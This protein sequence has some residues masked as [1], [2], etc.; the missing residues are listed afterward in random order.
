M[1]CSDGTAPATPTAEYATQPAGSTR[2][3]RSLAPTNT[4]SLEALA[5]AVP[6]AGTSTSVLTLTLTPPTF[7][8]CSFT[9]SVPDCDSF[10]YVNPYA[11]AN[12]G[13][14]GNPGSNTHAASY[15]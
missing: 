13:S 2:V 12:N 15:L 5:T 8:S 6:I 11:S 4:A 10:S 9:N 1:S 3:E 7:N 14:H